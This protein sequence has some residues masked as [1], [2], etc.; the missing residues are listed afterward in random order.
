MLIARATL[1]DDVI[2]SGIN[3]CGDLAIPGSKGLSAAESHS[4]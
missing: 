3:K 2:F 4:S 1:R